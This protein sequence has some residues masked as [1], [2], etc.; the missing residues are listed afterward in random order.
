MISSDI[1]NFIITSGHK[2]IPS[3]I[4]AENRLR[5][6][7]I[8]EE[9]IIS[10][11][12]SDFEKLE[13]NKLWLNLHFKTTKSYNTSF[14]NDIKYDWNEDN[15]GPIVIPQKGQEIE[16]KK[17]TLPLYKKIIRDY[18]KNKLE[19]INDKILINDV[20]TT[21]YKFKMDYWMMGDNRY[22]SKARHGA[23]YQRTTLWVGQFL[24]GWV[25]MGSM[26]G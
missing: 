15:F 12:N 21:F 26:M 24:F 19:F 23:M 10:M 3:R 6:T 8:K 25:L 14:P 5:V 17:Q 1:E 11:T 22:N 16:L 2:G 20:E 7:E 4:I 18:E 9:K 13:N